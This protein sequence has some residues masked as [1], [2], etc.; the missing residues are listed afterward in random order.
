MCNR[1]VI[2]IGEGLQKAYRGMATRRS[3]LIIG[4]TCDITVSMS[5]FLACPP[6]PL[7]GFESR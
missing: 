3:Y 7:R 2:W 4:V 5:A 1:P 6:M